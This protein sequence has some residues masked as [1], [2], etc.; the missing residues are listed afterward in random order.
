MFSQRELSEPLDAVRTA[1]APE[2]L[3]LD[4][5][6]D[7]ETLNAAVAEELLLVTDDI[8]PVT[9][10]DDWVPETAPDQ[11]AQLASDELTVG[12]PG[13][14]GLAWT[15]QTEPA[16][17]FVK[18][19]LTGSPDAFIE[20]LIAEALVEVS[21][22]LPEQFLGFFGEQ[23]PALAAAVESHLD[24]AAT[25]QLAAA[26]FDAYV[27]RQSHAEFAAWAESYPALHDAWV[28]AGER[29]K[30]RLG[31]LSSAVAT[32]ETPF[33]DAAELACAAVKHDIAVPTP[34]G[35][36]DTEAYT[37]YGAEY[38]VRWA[39]KTIDSLA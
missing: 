20:F 23:Y 15:R 34:F 13:D 19:R 26:L 14:G 2:T 28:E 22:D 10:P 4:C 32:G 24:A 30:P 25:Y 6:R 33:A 31:E 8:D 9:Y 29:L 11:L 16:V 39:E 35:A 7:F 17:V 3:V 5:E 12:M 18:P 27:G 36:L 38:A 1:Y 37:E 21:L